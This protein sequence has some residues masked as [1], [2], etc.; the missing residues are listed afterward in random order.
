MMGVEFG[1]T[2][3][4]WTEFVTDVNW[5][6]TNFW[7]G[8]AVNVTATE[9]ANGY[10]LAVP[11]LGF[12][13]NSLSISINVSYT[14]GGVLNTYSFVYGSSPVWLYSLAYYD[15]DVVDPVITDIP[16]NITV[17]EGYTGLSLSWTATD[18]NAGNYTITRDVTTVVTTTNW[19]SG[20]PVVYNIP[21]GLSAGTYIFTIDFQDTSL[22]SNTSAVML[23]VLVP[24]TTDPVI[25]STPSDI[26]VNPGALYQSFSWTATDANPATYTI[27]R[28]GTPIV[29]DQPWVS[30]T[31][32]VHTVEWAIHYV[33][34]PTTY[35]ITFTD[36]GA[37]TVSDSATL[38]VNPIPPETTTPPGIPGFEPLIVIGIV[39]IGSIGLIVL[40]RKKR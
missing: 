18:A 31:P 15:S 13:N 19:T 38:T 32:V 28:N 5:G 34:G 25:T 3:I 20:A 10:S 4:N 21:D 33:I 2:G 14:S 9:E 1:P 7:G 11:A 12:L 16:A 37:N 6:M 35:E 40:K 27:T 8:D 29:I 17:D 30:G 39:A 26:T 36:G 23:T 22:A 24:D